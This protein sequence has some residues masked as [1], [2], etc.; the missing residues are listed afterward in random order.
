MNKQEYNEHLKNPRW[1]KKRLEILNRDKFSC[2]VCGKGIDTNTSLHV[3]HITY[4]KG[5][6]PWEY[7]NSNFVTLCAHCHAEAHNRDLNIC[8]SFHKRHQHTNQ[9]KI[10]FYK[11]LLGNSLYCDF[12]PTQQIVYSF[13]VSKSITND[14]ELFDSDGKTINTDN[15]YDFYHHCDD[16]CI[17][18]LVEISSSYASKA[19]DITPKTYFSALSFL[20]R[21]GF[22]QGRNILFSPELIKNGYFELNMC[23]NL[24]KQLLIFHS[25]LFNLSQNDKYEIY[26]SSKFLALK[27]GVSASTLRTMI[28]SLSKRGLV[29]R[30]INQNGS[31]GKLAIIPF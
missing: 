12:T 30:N 26:A 8:L 13:L 3:H 1:Q 20:K 28:T 29:V 7:D 14:K 25:W 4:R 9:T 21:H 2:V 6:M 16:E 27:M 18:D 5:C 31:Y 11:Y 19:L 10:I 17:I 22:I 23:L 24:P 15:I